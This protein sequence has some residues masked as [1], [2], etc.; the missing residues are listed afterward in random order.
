MQGWLIGGLKV[1]KRMGPP[2]AWTQGCGPKGRAQ[3][4]AVAAQ[5]PKASELML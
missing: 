3:S 4:V 5:R 2:G 1:N